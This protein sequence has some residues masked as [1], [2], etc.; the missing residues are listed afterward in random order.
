MNETGVEYLKYTPAGAEYLRQIN[1]TESDRR[2][3][4]A[5]QDL[6]VRIAPPGASLFDFGAGAGIDARYFAERG[7]MVEAYDSDPRMR[8]FFAEHCRNLI[9]SGRIVL[10]CSGYREFV[11]RKGP[12]TARRADLVLADFAP[13]NLIDDL[14]ELFAKFAALTGPNG[15]V[16]TS[17]LSPYFV[18]EMKTRWWWRNAPRLLRDGHFFAPGPQAP[19]YRRRLANFSALCSPYFTLTRVFRGLPPLW[20]QHSTGADFSRGPR[21]AWLQATTSRFMFLLFEKR[22]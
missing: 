6:V 14:H 10:D 2:A 17:V 16:L 12:V 4:S 21:F 20:K 13:L 11:T 9:D 1:S 22:T 19:H 7:F 3:R 5:F 8:E 15:K 18:S